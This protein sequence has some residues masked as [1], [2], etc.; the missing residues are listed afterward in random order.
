MPSSIP[1]GIDAP[2]G[3]PLPQN[4]PSA[5]LDN[6]VDEDPAHVQKRATQVLGAAV[7]DPNALD[8]AGWCIVFP[9]NKDNSEIKHALQPLLDLRKSQAGNLFAILEND[10]GVANGDTASLWLSRRKLDPNRIVDPTQGVP[11]YVLL[12]GSPQEISFEFQYNLDASW[13]VGRLCFGNTADYAAYAKKVVAAESTAASK[14]LSIV[15]TRHLADEAS[16]AMHDYVALPLANGDANHPALG[17]KRRFQ[18]QNLL[19]AQATKANILNLLAGKQPGGRPSLLFSGTHGLRFD[20]TDPE[21]A[22]KQGAILCADTPKLGIPVQPDWMIQERDLGDLS[23]DGMIHFFFACY[24]AGCP[25]NDT[26]NVGQNGTP[27]PLMAQATFAKLATGLL[28]RGGLAVIGHIDRAWTTSFMGPGLPAI[29]DFRFAMEQILAGARVGQALDFF[30]QRWAK[31]SIELSDLL[32]NRQL[33][34]QVSDDDLTEKWKARNDARN[35]L[36]LGDPAVR[37]TLGT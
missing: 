12:A 1:L 14:V 2:T 25:A 31:L 9:A 5:V 17:S 29:Q 8:Q 3:N 36:V 30:N 6:L 19:A 33:P 16:Q 37:L 13:A 21:Q 18:Q 15:A 34:G 32:Q 22:I 10:G 27:I 4:I 20:M 24:S 35:Y 7:E 11:Y 23:L 26:Y 28:S